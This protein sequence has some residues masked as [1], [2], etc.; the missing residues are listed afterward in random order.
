M[1]IFRKFY[2]WIL[3]SSFIISIIVLS[4][5]AIGKPTQEHVSFFESKI[6]PVLIEHC[7]ECHGEKKQKGGLRLDFKQGWQI[8]GDSGQAIYPKKPEDSL[9]FKAVEYESKELEMPPDGKLSGQVIDDFKAWISHGAYD[10]RN[11]DSLS[12]QKK[13]TISIEEGKKFWSFRPVN[14][15]EPRLTSKDI[16]P[17]SKIDFYI[18]EKLQEKGIRPVQDASREALIRRIYFDLIGL[19]PS[20]AE[21]ESFVNDKSQTAYEVIVDK[22]LSSSHFGERWGRHWLDV[23]R[24][25]ESSGGGRTLLFPDA[26]RYRDY[27]IQSFNND[28]PYDKFVQEQIAGDLLHSDNWHDEAQ[29][30]TATSFLLLGPT[31]Y[32]LQDKDIL[33]MDIID[34]Q[35]DTLGKSFM[36]MT[37]NC[38]RC[39]D[40]K[41][42]PIP[43]ADYYAMAGIFKSTKSVV[44]NNVSTW[45]KRQLP[46]S[47]EKLTLAKS[48]QQKISSL[49]SDLKKLKDEQKI[50][51]NES[52]RN[53]NFGEAII[54]DNSEAIVNGTWKN[55]TAVKG[56]IGDDYIFT[57]MSPTETHSVTF[58]PNI[59][60]KSK[61]EIFISYTSSGNRHSK[62]KVKIEHFNG[63]SEI[64]VD[65]SKKGTQS[66]TI[67]KLGVFECAPEKPCAVRISN[68][69]VKGE[70]KVVIADAIAF[71]PIRAAKLAKTQEQKKETLQKIQAQKLAKKIKSIEDKIKELKDMSPALPTVMAVEESKK[72]EDI[73]IAIRGVVSNKGPIVPRGFLKV[74]PIEG[75]SFVPDNSSG[76]LE[77]ARW[78]SNENHPLTSRVM[79]NRVWSWLFTEGIVR[80]VDNFGTTGDKP[81]HPELLDYLAQRFID[82]DWSVKKLIKEIVTSRV[83]QL[84][85]HIDSNAKSQDPDNK[86][87]WRM[88]RKRLD[89]ESIRDA[90]LYFS[91]SLDLKKGGSNIKKG[92]SIEYGYVFDTTRRSV[93]IPVFRNT[94]PE[95]FQTFD[96]ADPNIQTGK[97]TASAVAPQALLM[98]NSPFVIE[99]AKKTYKTFKNQENVVDIDKLY[100]KILGRKPY[101][102]EKQYITSFVGNSTGSTRELRWEQVILTL[103]Q[104]IDFRYLN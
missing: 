15:E 58:R 45:N 35:M 72:I 101:L 22:L 60:E 13:E 36:G 102:N 49:D 93:Y 57:Q 62:V 19:P 12:N 89:A 16:W 37:L 39:H 34:E 50:L 103:F 32:E 104:S 100:L 98:M 54:V 82:L 9:V 52:V 23:V 80:S 33:E 42:D 31:N 48:F 91:G 38:A 87:L 20:A 11:N 40:H 30:I 18:L 74:A 69:G 66:D 64:S 43:T 28:L 92:T 65:Q 56:F 51:N 5:P 73:P 46:A 7:I 61:Y 63:K 95:I 83:Y 68:S 24:F 44:H 99:Q 2:H 55:S 59:Q 84:G 88:P 78:I 14:V 96:F 76:R 17:I 21:V 10:P 75:H 81:T 3:Q 41:F 86:L 71:K 70:N 79:V 4:S 1:F 97:R 26:W 25:A 85:T 29:K 77:L 27:V 67:E 53:F 90:L 94:L 47:P 8:G 6:R